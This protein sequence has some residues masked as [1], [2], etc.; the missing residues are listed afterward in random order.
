MEEGLRRTLAGL[1]DQLAGTGDTA[2]PTLIWTLGMKTS[3]RNALRGVVESVTDG[4]VNAVVVLRIG[5]NA[6]IVAVVTRQS[7]SDLGLA[8]GATAVALINAGSIILATG[9]ESL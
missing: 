7:I 3:A 2:L 1:Q 9:G 4:A 5:E 8:P 6:V